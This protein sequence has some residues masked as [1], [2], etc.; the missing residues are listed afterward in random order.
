MHFEVDSGKPIARIK[1]DGRI[2]CLNKHGSLDYIQ[3]DKT[4]IPILNFEDEKND[5]VMVIA[6]TGAGKSTLLN[7][8]IKQKLELYPEKRVFVFSAFNGDKSLDSGLENIIE[9]LDDGD[10]TIEDFEES[11]V[12]FDDIDSITDPK[13]EKKLYK[14]LTSLLQSGRHYNTCLFFAGHVLK[15]GQKTKYLIN[16]ANNIFIFPQDG[17]NAQK[18]KWLKDYIGLPMKEINKILGSD[19]RWVRIHNEMP[20]YIMTE[21]EIYLPSSKY[22]V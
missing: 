3:T 14:L 1:E 8:L 15:N 18:E 6:K 16:E 13:V 4:L 22:K 9:Y 17:A 5:R 11:I 7:K 2:I 20:V 10:Y 19:E 21:H 12:I